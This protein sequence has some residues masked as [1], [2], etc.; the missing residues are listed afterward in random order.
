MSLSTM[1]PYQLINYGVLINLLDMIQYL[2]AT[3]LA[4]GAPAENDSRNLANFCFCCLQLVLLLSGF[5]HVEKEEEKIKHIEQ[6][7][8]L[9]NLP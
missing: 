6:T 2:G 7:Q 3:N 5:G 1:V 8:P 4:T 9:C